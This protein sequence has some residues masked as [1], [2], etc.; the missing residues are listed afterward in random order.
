MRCQRKRRICQPPNPRKKAGFAWILAVLMG[1]A[2][3]SYR[4]SLFPRSPPRAC[5][6]DAPR[7]QYTADDMGG[8]HCNFARRA[9][10]CFRR[11]SDGRNQLWLRTLDSPSARSLAGTDDGH[12]PFWSPDS[13]SNR[14]LLKCQIDAAG[15]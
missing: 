15:C 7:D 11:C 6:G 14:V 10:N 9:K 2:F 13:R 3:C 8:I 5:A 12:Y 4:S 1:L